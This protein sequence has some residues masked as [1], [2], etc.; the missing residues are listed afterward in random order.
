MRLWTVVP[1]AAEKRQQNRWAPSSRR[2]TRKGSPHRSYEHKVSTAKVHSLRAKGS[3]LVLH[4]TGPA[5]LGGEGAVEV[6]KD[7]SG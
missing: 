6:E 2:H 1:A 5:P 4:R 3:L 7:P